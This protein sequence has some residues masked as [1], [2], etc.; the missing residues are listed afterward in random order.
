MRPRDCYHTGTSTV[1]PEERLLQKEEQ[2]GSKGLIHGSNNESINDQLVHLHTSAFLQGGFSKLSTL[3][4]DC[5][6]DLKYQERRRMVLMIEGKQMMFTVKNFYDKVE[7]S[8]EFTYTA[9]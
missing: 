2:H 1:A 8:Y 5:G 7:A 6:K 9:N 4:V 3:N